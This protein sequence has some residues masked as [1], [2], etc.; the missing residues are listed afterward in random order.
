MKADKR[1]ASPERSKTMEKGSD[2][3]AGDM[4][5]KNINYDTNEIEFQFRD[6]EEL[7]GSESGSEGEE[8]FESKKLHDRG[9][10]IT[11]EVLKQLR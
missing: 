8:E 1:S 11:D 9:L 6:Q 10:E 5:V 7:S 4:F 2:M 3:R